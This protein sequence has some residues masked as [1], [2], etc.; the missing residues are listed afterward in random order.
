MTDR[1][2]RHATFAIESCYPADPRKVFAAWAD[3]EARRIWMDDPDFSSDGT[4]YQLDFRVGGYERFGGLDR[5]GSTYRC[6]ALIYDIVPE[7]RIVYR[8]EMYAGEARM[9]VSLTTV[10]IVPHTVGARLIYTEQGVWLDG[11]DTPEARE[12]GWT[13]ILNHLGAYLT[14]QA[15]GGALR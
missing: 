11:I 14:A 12:S 1:S 3:G 5:D 6:E 8:Y 15:A 13:Y 2:V 9:S 4:A 7:Q 10:D